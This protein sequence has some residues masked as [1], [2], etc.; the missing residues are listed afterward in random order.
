MVSSQSFSRIQRRISLSPVAFEETPEFELKLPSGFDPDGLAF[1]R[2]GSWL[3]TANHGK[4]SVSIFQRGN[5]IAAGASNTVT[6]NNSGAFGTGQTVNGNGSFGFGDPNIINGNGTFVTGNNNTVNG[7]TVA[8]NGDNIQVVGSNNTL[9]STASAAGSSVFGLGNTVNATNALVMGNTNTVTGGNGFSQSPIVVNAPQQ[10]IAVVNG[11]LIDGR[12][13]APWSNGAVLGGVRAHVTAVTS[14][15]RNTRM[16]ERVDLTQPR[17]QAAS[18][19]G[20]AQQCVERAGPG[21]EPVSDP[22]EE[23]SGHRHREVARGHLRLDLAR[24]DR[25]REHEMT[26]EADHDVREPVGR[27]QHIE[28]SVGRRVLTARCRVE[29]DAQGMH[30]PV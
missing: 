16:I 18:N 11:S 1:S 2:C 24:F 3:A 23:R 17:R 28:R 25:R 9:A 21:T 26:G 14:R 15:P 5:S 20:R 7:P 30:A 4:H 22:C 6:G 13:I 10:G 12:C 8:G 29:E 19:A 27:R